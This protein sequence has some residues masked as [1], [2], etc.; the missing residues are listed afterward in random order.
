VVQVTL[1]DDGGTA[2]DGADTG[3]PHILTITVTH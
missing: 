2:N 3:S 1:R